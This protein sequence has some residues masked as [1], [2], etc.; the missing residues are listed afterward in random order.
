[1]T[2]EQK[3]KLLEDLKSHIKIDN[4]FFNLG[5]VKRKHD[6]YNYYKSLTEDEKETMSNDIAKVRAK[7]RAEFEE[8]RRNKKNNN[9]N[10]NNNNINNNSSNTDGYS[11]NININKNNNSDDVDDNEP[12]G[13]FFVDHYTKYFSKKQENEKPKEINITSNT[14]YSKYDT[15]N[16]PNDN[17]TTTTTTDDDP[18]DIHVN[19]YDYDKDFLYENP[20]YSFILDRINKIHTHRKNDSL[21]TYYLIKLINKKKKK[22]M[23][24]L[25]LKMKKERK[26]QKEKQEELKRARAARP[27]S[28]VTN[29]DGNVSVDFYFYDDTP[30]EP[31]RPGHL[32]KRT[33]RLIRLFCVMAGF[34]TYLLIMRRFESNKRRDDGKK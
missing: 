17:F 4:S 16:D 12:I 29:T 1:M 14:D 8:K 20:L 5:N 21:F 7:V 30:D 28:K 22:D 33:K 2:N 15:N 19:K 6:A 25:E 24:I 27:T 31:D 32:T 26:I 18:G 34:M 9:N 3:Q 13:L 10:I 11:S 23:A